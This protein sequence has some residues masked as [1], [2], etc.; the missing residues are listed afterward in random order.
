MYQ[1]A[2]FM[3]IVVYVLKFLVV[4]LEARSGTGQ[5]FPDTFM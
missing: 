4:R 2:E 1:P 3:P 5:Y